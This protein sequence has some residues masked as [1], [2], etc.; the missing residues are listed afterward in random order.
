[1]LKPVSEYWYGYGNNEAIDYLAFFHSCLSNWTK[2][3]APRG[4]H[5]ESEDGA[6]CT[7]QNP[8]SAVSSHQNTAVILF[9]HTVLKLFGIYSPCHVCT[10]F[11]K[12]ADL[13]TVV[14]YKSEF[15]VKSAYQG[16]G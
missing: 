10:P 13:K 2:S 7:V 15:S 6:H 9:R 12:F 1:L 8:K 4:K 11:Q 5:T 14:R 3:K 16:L